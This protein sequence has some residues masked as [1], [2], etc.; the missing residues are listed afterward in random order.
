MNLWELTLYCVQEYFLRILL[1]NEL[2]KTKKKKK[3]RRSWQKKVKSIS[4]VLKRN[5]HQR[6]SPEKNQSFNKERRLGWFS[7][8]V[9]FSFR[10]QGNSLGYLF[11]STSDLKHFTMSLSSVKS[12]HPTVLQ[13]FTQDC[14]QKSSYDIQIVRL[15][16][17]PPFLILA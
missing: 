13:L 12:I 14:Q 7:V 2:Q 17:V 10:F 15:K 11:L 16:S 8:N 6:F 1:K 3:S 4:N 5:S 9:I